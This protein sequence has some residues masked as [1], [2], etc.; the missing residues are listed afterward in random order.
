MLKEVGAKFLKEWLCQSLYM[1][2]RHGQQQKGQ[3]VKPTT[4]EVRF[5]K[6]RQ[7]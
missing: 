5:M 2:Q 3:E 7:I 4:T 6:K 1:I